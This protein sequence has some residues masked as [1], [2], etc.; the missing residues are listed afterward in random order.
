MLCTSEAFCSI[1]SMTSG[2]PIS[3]PYGQFSDYQDLLPQELDDEHIMSGEQQPLN[4]PSVH[5]FFRHNVRLF[6]VMDDILLRSRNAKTV[7]YF[8]SKEASSNTRIRRP[9]SSVNAALSLLNCILQL[10]GHLLSWHEYLPSHLEFPLEGTEALQGLP[11][12]LQLQVRVLWSRF[13][14]MRI[15]LH[16]QTILF[17]LQPPD[18]TTW[19]INGIQEWPPIFSDCSVDSLVGASTVFRE[20][21][22]PSTVEITLAHLSAKTCVSSAI[23]QMEVVNMI[24]LT[25]SAGEGWWWSFNG[26]KVLQNSR[27]SS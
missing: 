24:Q 12:W 21:G 10:D 16:R 1:S 15:L 2:R 4:S 18:R 7:A 26:R 11:I 6:H 25:R 20:S 3:I 5:S 22:T 13:L 19:P 23:F 9:V 27:L 8:E 17:L 14:H